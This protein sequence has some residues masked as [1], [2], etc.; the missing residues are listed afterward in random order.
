MSR[1]TEPEIVTVF[2]AWERAWPPKCCHT[3][4]HYLPSGLCEEFGTEPPEDF[5]ATPEACALWLQDLPF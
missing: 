1:H 3:C 2:R 5:A 4:D